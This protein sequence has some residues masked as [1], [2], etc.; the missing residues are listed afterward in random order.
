MGNVSWFLLLHYYKILNENFVI[1]L[2]TKRLSR[3][4]NSRYTCSS[5][6]DIESNDNS[7][8]VTILNCGKYCQPEISVKL[9]MCDE[10]S[11]FMF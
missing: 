11:L 9:K 5:P 1:R 4:Q 8:F 2:R 10:N 7:C 3:Y 6:G